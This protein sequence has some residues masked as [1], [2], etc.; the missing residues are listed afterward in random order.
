MTAPNITSLDYVDSVPLQGLLRHVIPFVSELPQA[1]AMDL[2]RQKYTDFARRTRILACEIVNDYQSGVQDYYLEPPTDHE[3]YSIVGVEGGQY[4]YYWYGESRI[5]FKHNF[6]VIDNNCIKL[7]YPPSV[8]Q[9]QGLK[10]YVT[11]LPKPCIA[12]IPRSIATPFGQM[13]GRGVVADALYIPN[14]PWTNPD[15]ARRYQLDYERMLLSARALS[16]SNRKVDS[17]SIKPV[18]IL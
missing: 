12:T 4:G 14:K 8:D 6:D 16:V 5:Q 15:L 3:I 11:L 2:L 17:N 18:R 10:V 7:A 1:F 13:I 9:V